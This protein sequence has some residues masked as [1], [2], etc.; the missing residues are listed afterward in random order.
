METITIQ[1]EELK[2]LIE[3]SVKEALSSEFSKL[4]SLILPFV[5]NEEQEDIETNYGTP[6]RNIAKTIEVDI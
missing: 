1:K 2:I 4:Y 5:S 3:K 6:G